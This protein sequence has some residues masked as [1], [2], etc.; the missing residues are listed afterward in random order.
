MEEAPSDP[1]VEHTSAGNSTFEAAITRV[2][3]V[4]STQAQHDNALRE[5]LAVIGRTLI[6]L[7]EP[8]AQAATDTLTSQPE[9]PAPACAETKASPPATPPPA[10][11]P[12]TQADLQRL[13]RVM[14]GKETLADT[15]PSD[16]TGRHRIVLAPPEPPDLQIVIDRG[17]AKAAILRWYAEQPAS[18]SIR[19]TPPQ[20]LIVRAK[21][22]SGGQ[23]WMLR[24]DGS[25]AINHSYTPMLAASFS[26]TVEISTTLML[27]IKHALAQSLLRSAIE[28]AAEAQSAL[29]AAVRLASISVADNDQTTLFQWL[30]HYA[31]EEQ[32]FIARYMRKDDPADPLA[33]E[34][35]LSRVRLLGSNVARI[36][37]QRRRQRKLLGA[38]RYR[39]KKEIVTATSPIEHATA[40]LR[41]GETLDQLMES[42]MP[43]THPSLRPLLVAHL[44]SLPQGLDLP[45]R[46]AYALEAI[47]A[48]RLNGLVNPPNS[49][50][51]AEDDD[52]PV[53]TEIAGLLRDQ[54]VVVLGGDRRPYTAQAIKEA[55]TLKELIWCTTKEGQSYLSLEPYIR[56]PDVALVILAIRWASHN[57]SEATSLC[58]RYNKLLVRLP[59]GYNA[60]QMAH[61]IMQ[62]VGE[63]LQSLTA[64][65]EGSRDVAAH[66]S[67]LWLQ[68][69]R[70]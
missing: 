5:S 61:Q 37:E 46:A 11:P 31:S 29:K 51:V 39:I 1:S 33:W 20:N 66:S 2:L 69:H 53:V 32:M 8:P 70:N 60:S 27:I 7:A 43:P 58:I 49:I 67:S 62:Q 68:A 4:L 59:A 28:L 3:Q 41:I 54:T 65:R 48:Y 19:T 21:A 42:G 56:R 6:D 10:S 34:D 36:A 40:W 14:M 47:T 55:F 25:L 15:I 24:P 35:R 30:R 63:R 57:L 12:A 18:A 45:P 52:D 22:L 26:A 13:A 64:E 23:L 50:E 17:D 44:D 38:L 16:G 9:L